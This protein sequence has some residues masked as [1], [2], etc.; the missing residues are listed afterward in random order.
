M[1]IVPPIPRNERRQMRK[2]VQKT[3][4]KN[5]ARRIMAILLL[6]QGASVSQVAKTLCTVHSS[7]WRWIDRFKALGW[8]G[9]Y[10]LSAGRHPRWNLTPLLPVLFYLLEHSPQQFGHI[11]SRWSLSFFIFQIKKLFNIKLSISTLYRFFCKNRIVWRRAA[12]TL[13]VPDPEYDEKMRLI[14][15]ALS[16]A[17]EKHPVVYEDEVDIHFNPKIGAD[18][19]FK[20]QQKRIITPGQNQ[21]YY[22]AGTLDVQTKHVLY[23]GSSKKNS[24]LFIKML[25]VLKRYYQGVKTLTVIL[26]NYCIH[27]SRAVQRWL[28]QN[29]T[30]ILLFLPVYSP[31]LNKIEYLWHTLHE[32][33]TRNHCCRYMWQ[34]LSNVKKF[35]KKSAN[36]L[37]QRK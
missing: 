2:I 33:V 34:L 8:A 13:Q 37:F 30:I 36:R 18:W 5:Y 23:T 21:K 16:L 20:G 6:H 22:I 3:A 14:T 19:Y 12:P 15:K 9:L 29:P 31:W 24:L 4:D 25:E 35:L 27:K 32:T 17:S 26:D 7:V 11:R 28:A 10:P 1:A